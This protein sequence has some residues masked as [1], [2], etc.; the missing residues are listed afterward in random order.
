MPSGE[1]YTPKLKKYVMFSP[2]NIIVTCTPKPEK[3]D[4]LLSPFD[5]A[6]VGH[7]LLRLEWDFTSL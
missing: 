2:I 3:T 6:P 4:M 1:E 5:I 7:V